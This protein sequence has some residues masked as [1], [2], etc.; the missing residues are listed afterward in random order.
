MN[1]TYRR[2]SEAWNLLQ[3]RDCLD[4]SRWEIVQGISPARE[5][6]GY[7]LEFKELLFFNQVY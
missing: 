7:S 4:D 1:K 6:H 3:L 2:E 5:I